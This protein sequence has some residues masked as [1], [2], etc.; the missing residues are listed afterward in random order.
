MFQAKDLNRIL[1]EIP[2]DLLALARASENLMKNWYF[3]PP[4]IENFD[5]NPNHRHIAVIGSSGSG[6]STLVRFLLQKYSNLI[7]FDCRKNERICTV[8][9]SSEIWGQKLIQ[10]A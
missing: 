7:H 6:K 5:G 4:K 8:I 2:I 3:P 10:I 1:R 9:F